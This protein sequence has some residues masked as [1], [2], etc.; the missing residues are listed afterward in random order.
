MFPVQRTAEKT[1]QKTIFD[2]DSW[3]NLHTNDFGAFFY[4][5][6]RL[7]KISFVRTHCTILTLTVLDPA[8]RRQP[9]MSL[10]KFWLPVIPLIPEDSVVSMKMNVLKMVALRTVVIMSVESQSH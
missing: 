2:Q 9:S 3:N 5:C 4:A 10:V 1:V 6:L 8:I 7:L